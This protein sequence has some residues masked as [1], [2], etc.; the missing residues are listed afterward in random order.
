MSWFSRILKG[1]GG[2]LAE[3]AELYALIRGARIR[4]S[5]GAQVPVPPVRV[6]RVNEKSVWLEGGRLVVRQ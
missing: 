6:A 3:M 1:A 5:S 2:D 4:L